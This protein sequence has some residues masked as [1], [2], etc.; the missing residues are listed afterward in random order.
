MSCHDIGRGMASV[1]DVVLELYE[2]GQI[3]K[4]A[5]IR[6]VNAC[7]NGVHWC[8]GNE[9]EAMESVV[10]AGYCGLCFEKKEGLSNVCDNDLGYPEK[11][12]VFRAYDNTAAHNVMCPECK[13]RVI[14]EWK[15]KHGGL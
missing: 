14:A 11:Y 4:D 12:Q 15:A 10:E 1:A 7:R 3:N 2:S 5:A 9:N 6:L 8:D 13:A